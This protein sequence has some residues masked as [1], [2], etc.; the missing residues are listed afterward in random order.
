MLGSAG[1]S[2][3]AHV[4]SGQCRIGD[5]PDEKFVTKVSGGRRVVQLGFYVPQ[6]GP[7]R[8]SYLLS[9]WAEV[10]LAKTQLSISGMSQRGPYGVDAAVV[11]LVD[12]NYGL[13]DQWPYLRFAAHGGE[14]MIIRYRLTVTQPA[15]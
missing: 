1:E 10:S 4:F 7:F 6:A 5:T 15:N 11:Q 12:D 8:A 3:T 14:P 13:G 9:T 2:M